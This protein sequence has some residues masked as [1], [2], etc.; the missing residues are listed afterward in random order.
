MSALFSGPPKPPPP[1][2][3]Q[4]MPDFADP[5]ILAA[6]RRRQLEAATRSGRA[7]TMLTNTDDYS[8]DKLGVR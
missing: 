8:G 2:P 7:S 1:P 6:A 5:A 3:P 4:P